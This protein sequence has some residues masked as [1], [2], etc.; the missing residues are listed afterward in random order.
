MSHPAAAIYA[1]MRKQATMDS[2][3]KP[4]LE[5]PTMD[6]AGSFEMHNTSLQA[7]SI[8]NVWLETAPDELDS[9][10]GYG[11]RLLAMIMGMADNNSDGELSEDEHVVIEAAM[12]FFAQADTRISLYATSSRQ[13]P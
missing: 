9:G 4:K 7:A 5:K 1:G 2:C 13:S 11:D 6:D 10:E 3:K 12:P 8:I